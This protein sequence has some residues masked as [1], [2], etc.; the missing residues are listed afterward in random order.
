MNVPQFVPWIG[1]QEYLALAGCFERTWITEG[2]ETERFLD[3]LRVLTGARHAVLAPNGTLALVLGLRALGIGAGDEV[4]VPDCT[5]VGS[6]TAVE[7]TGARP[8]FCDVQPHSF[9]IDV[10]SAS[11]RV[12]ERTRAIMPVHLYGTT[13]T[14]DEVLAFAIQHHLYVIEDAAQAIGVRRWGQHAGTFGDVGCFSF[15]ADKTITTGEGG[16]VVTNDEGVYQRLCLLRN[17]GRVQ[18]GSFVHPEIGYNFRMTDMQAALGLVQL[19][20]L[21]AVLARKQHVLRWYHERLGD[22][23]TFLQPDQGADWVPFR[24]VVFTEHAHAAMAAMREQGIETRTVFYPLHRQPCF[25]GSQPGTDSDF[26]HSTYAYEHG[27]CLPTFPTIEE[28]QVDAV[29]D[30]LLHF[31][32]KRPCAKSS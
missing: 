22:Y 31:L 15:F 17:Q 18:R 29:C 20:K 13:A 21:P 28:A 14:M 2:P 6:A 11:H 8:V 27:I 5:F 30:A 16:A 19:Q 3:E 7:M 9:Q 25:A 10:G 12:T 4:I 24:V 1:P 32:E 26:P 23:V